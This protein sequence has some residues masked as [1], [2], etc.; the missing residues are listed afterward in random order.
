MLRN[1]SFLVLNF[2]HK[3]MG[4]YMPHVVQKNSLFTRS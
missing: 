2:S 4:T 1:F 3:L